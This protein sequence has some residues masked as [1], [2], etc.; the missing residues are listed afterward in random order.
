MADY[1]EANILIDAMVGR[2]AEA[3]QKIRIMLPNERDRFMRALSRAEDWIAEVEEEA[4]PTER[5]A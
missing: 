5:A 1:I 2:E 4:A 3:K